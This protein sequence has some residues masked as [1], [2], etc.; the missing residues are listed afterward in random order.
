[1]LLFMRLVAAPTLAT[2]QELLHS[3]FSSELAAIA[4]T[5]EVVVA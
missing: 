5:E 3:A 4:P 2:F 1:M